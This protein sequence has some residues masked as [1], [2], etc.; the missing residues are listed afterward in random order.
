MK[1]VAGV[2]LAGAVAAGV[3]V[4]SGSGGGA[5]LP[6]EAPPAAEEHAHDAKFKLVPV[7]GV[8]GRG[9]KGEFRHARMGAGAGI[10]DGPGMEASFC[11]TDE[12]DVDSACNA[13]W[14]EAG[15]FNLLRRWDRETGLVTTLAGSACG[16]LDGPLGRARFGGWGGGGYGASS[17]AVSGDGQHVFIRDS[18]NGG[19]LRHVDLEAGT[20]TTLGAFFPARDPAG[21]I[22]ILDPKGGRVPPGKGYKPLKTAAL[23]WQRGSIGFGT[24]WVLDAKHERLYTHARSPVGWFDLKTGKLGG[25]VTW[26]RGS[27]TPARTTDTTGP[28]ATSNFQCPIGLSISPGGRYLYVGGGDSYSFWRLDLEKKYVH[29]FGL[30]PDGSYGFRDGP[31]EKSPGCMHAMWPSHPRFAADGSACWSGPSGI[32]RLAPVK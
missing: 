31:H 26:N 11:D 10:L 27:K 32:F 23:E 20:V 22:Y 19:K 16:D 9:A 25:W 4:L 30:L 28:A 6:A 13:F 3:A 15:Q 29:I 5:T 12:I 8:R 17:I 24:W 14:T 1:L 7:M 2:V 18:G 21:E